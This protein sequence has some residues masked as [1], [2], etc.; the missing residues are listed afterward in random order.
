MKVSNTVAVLVIVLVLLG[1]YIWN[2]CKLH[3][4]DDKEKFTRT[5]LTGDTNCKFVRSHVDY[6]YG[7]DTDIPSKKGLP[8]PHAIAN[9]QDK[10]RPLDDGRINLIQDE[11]K[12]WDPNLLWVQYEND[13]KGCGNNKPY[14]VNDDK[15][16]W[17]LE[18][19]GDVWAAR[20]LESQRLPEHGP[21][22]KFPALVDQDM[23]KQE[24]F[25]PLYGGDHYLNMM[26][27]R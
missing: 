5:C 20:I 19:V 27:G 1:L 16:R 13:W 12:L 25:Q 6:M 23:I 11:Q 21:Q 10:L 18:D 15:T 3:S 24:V 9:E 2:G 17:S 7:D 8:F 26:L 22:G 4:K 14:I